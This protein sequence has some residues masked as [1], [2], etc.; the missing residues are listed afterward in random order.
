LIKLCYNDFM[1]KMEL[2][3]PV[4]NME[5]LKMA[6][7]YGADAVY[8]G[9]NQFNARNNIDGF[10]LGGLS[11][12]IDFAHL[13]DVKVYLALN[14]LFKD[15]ELQ[16]ALDVVVEA[17]N[18][19]IDAFIVQDLGLANLIKQNYPSVELHASTQM[20][21]HNLEGVK[22]LEKLGFSRVVLARETSKA[23]IE[24]ISKNSNVEIEFFV[25]GALC[26]SFSGNCYMCSHLVDKSGNRGVCQ[27]FC[28][29][30]YTFENHTTKTEGYLLSAKDICML[31]SLNE[32]SDLGVASLKIEGRARR[33]FY[34]AQACKI[35]REML[36]KGE[37]SANDLQ[38][39]NIAFN[40][41][42]TPAYF[43]GNGNIVSKIQGNNGLE[44]G[45]VKKVN[46]GAK[47]N[48]V[49]VSTNYN[50]QG[51]SGLK[52]IYNDQEIAS[53]GAYDVKRVGKL[54][55]ITTTSN[56]KVGSKVHIIQDE[57]L[58]QEVLSYVRKLPIDVGFVSHENQPITMRVRYNDIE[59]EMQGEV[60][61]K[62]KT[63]SASNE[64]I[65][66]QL[67]RSDVFEI[68]DFDC[69]TNG[70]YILNSSINK[71]RNNIY[72]ELQQKIIKK[73]QKNILNKINIKTINKTLLNSNVHDNKFNFK[74]INNINKLEYCDNLIFNYNNFNFE[75][76]KA[77]NDYCIDHK[78]NGYIDLP[79]FATGQD[80]KMIEQVL[81]KTSLGVVAN[82]L[83]AL[84]FECKML[85]GQ[86]LN[87][88]NSHTLNVLERLHKLDAVFVEELSD[89]EISTLQTDLHLLRRERVY[90]TLLHCPFKQNM[91]RDCTTCG[92]SDDATF[93]INSGKKF[94]IKRKKTSSCIFLLKD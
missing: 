10:N 16:D 23:E 37:Y 68:V 47:F 50:L 62:A 84:N 65:L 44:I 1:R 53:I 2:L 32:L 7:Y 39:L 6:V 56:I 28:R 55:R 90:M 89:Q 48:E 17:N 81:N 22:V 76:F 61:Q 58:E 69:Q 18:K 63:I 3:A 77:F 8:L 31:D 67:S 66:N 80:I 35:Y 92:Y 11:Q 85:G 71:L 21:V 93:I 73:Y 36:D 42:Y 54:Y 9:V 34:V 70:C 82:N 52:F 75:D 26:V 60:C 40:R 72:N 46:N 13:F 91:K 20:A 4:G 86:F 33:P 64:Q 43:N 78:I 41:G 83:Y 51:K 19:G 87:V 45:V 49:F 38:L 24:R 88:Y 15:S 5:S 25:Q 27:Q 59:V 74:I 12:A 14:I 29:L 79:N 30:P 57:A 94:K